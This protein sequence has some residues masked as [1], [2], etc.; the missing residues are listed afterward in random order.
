MQFILFALACFIFSSVSF[1]VLVVINSS[2][3]I[4]LL[5]FGGLEGV[6]SGPYTY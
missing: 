6:N 1:V 5:I 2:H 4:Y 3:Y